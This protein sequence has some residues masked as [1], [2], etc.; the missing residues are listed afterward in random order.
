MALQL[1][2]QDRKVGD[3]MELQ[4]RVQQ[5]RKVLSQLQRRANQKALHG[6]D[7]RITRIKNSLKTLREEA[8]EAMRIYEQVVGI[9]KPISPYKHFV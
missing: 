9:N 4:L 8:S 5:T 2:V 1:R 6:D 7:E 3:P